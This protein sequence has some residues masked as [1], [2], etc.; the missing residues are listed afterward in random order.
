MDTFSQ[1]CRL[2]I[3]IQKIQMLKPTRLLIALFFLAI[4]PYSHADDVI[5]GKVVGVADGDTITVLENLTQYKIRLFGIDT[6]E[7]RQ[8]FGNKAKQMT[9]DLVFG[10]EVRVVEMDI[11]QYGRIVG[12]VYVGNLC[13]NETLVEEGLA[14]VYRKYCIISVCDTWLEL[15]SQAREGKIGLWSHPN[16]VP[17]WEFRWKKRSPNLSQSFSMLLN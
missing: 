4:A 5:I 7:A 17:P 14:W 1:D 11:D 13:V 12:M 9:S 6:P 10:K 8:D 2:S 15:E 3:R 16:P